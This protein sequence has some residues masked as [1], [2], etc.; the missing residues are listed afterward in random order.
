MRLHRY[1]IIFLAKLFVKLDMAFHELPAV[2]GFCILLTVYNQ[3]VTGIMLALSLPSDSMYVSLSR[4]QEDVE[5]IY[6]DDMFL[7]HERGVD[8]FATFC[9]LHMFR[10]LYINAL[11]VSHEATWKGG[12]LLFLLAQFIIFTGL[13]LCCSHLSDVTLTIGLNAFSSFCLFIG[14]LDWVLAP[15]EELSIDALIRLGYLHYILPFV[16]G[17]FSIYHGVDMH[18][19]WKTEESFDGVYNELNWWDE[20]VINEVHQWLNLL[21]IAVISCLILYTE[22]EALHYELF[23]WGDVGMSVDVRYFGVAPHWYFRPYMGWLVVC[24]YHYLGL[25]GLIIFFVGFYF[26]PTVM[27]IGD[28]SEYSG[29][30]LMIVSFLFWVRDLTKRV[31]RVLPF[32]C[33][34]NIFYQITFIIFISCMW[35]SFS[36]L[37]YGRFFQSLG[38]NNASLLVYTYL[39]FYLCCPNLRR[40]RV[41]SFTQLKVF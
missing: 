4:E 23:M 10:K 9:F 19:N 26:Q 24:P 30:R 7:F 22:P 33:E 31:T 36:Y 29:V 40:P 13:T 28:Y 27:K 35:Y 1:L 6:T 37:P 5:T 34:Q 12:V 21:A 32:R 20:G 38:G 8:Y 17:F 3:V 15:G 25:L 39:F 16:L 11:T 14:K 18:Y 41:Y 2:L